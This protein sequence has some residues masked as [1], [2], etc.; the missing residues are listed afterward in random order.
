MAVKSVESIINRSNV[1]GSGQVKTAG[2]ISQGFGDHTGVH[3]VPGS[4]GDPIATTSSKPLTLHGAELPD[5]FHGGDDAEYGQCSTY[6]TPGGHIVEYN[7]TPGSERILI[8]HKEGHGVQICPDGSILIT[9]RRRIDAA[10]EDYSLTVGGDGNLKF[11]N[12]TIDVDQDFNVNVG[13]EYNVKSADKTEEIRGTSDTTVYG[14]H[15]RVVNGNQSN[16]VTGGGMY[17]YLDGLNTAVKGDSRYAVEGAMTIASSGVLT[18]T[19]EGEVIMTAPN[20]NIA[21]DNLSLFGDTGTIGGENI[22]AYVKNIYGVSG[23]FSARFKAP[24]FE[25]DLDGNA[26]TATTAG[27][28]LH[29]S[30]PDGTAAPSTY[31]PSVGTNPNYTVDDTARDETATA[32]PTAALLT[33]YKKSSKGPKVVKVDPDSVIKNNI[34]TSVKTGGVSDTKLTTRQVRSKMRDP[35]HRSNSE[36]VATHIA[37]GKLSPDHIKTSPPNVSS[38]EDTTNITVQGQTVMGSPSPALQSKRIRAV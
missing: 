34:D 18:M 16:I 19:S 26:L 35:A 38:V 15:S 12:L 33:E 5:D 20:T 22:I 11:T 23:D 2:I 10:S 36:F 32:L 9:G 6:V 27:T 31:T 24:V 4:E 29:Q 8:R 14:D 21:A 37:E 3:P 1:Q 7:D 25:G 30:Y 28:S 17:Q 13:G